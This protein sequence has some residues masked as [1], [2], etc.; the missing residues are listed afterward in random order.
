MA[1]QDERASGG[2]ETMQGNL[3]EKP[4]NA[5]SFDDNQYAGGAEPAPDEAD[6]SA[7]GANV[8]K[9]GGGT[10]S[11]KQAGNTGSTPN[12]SG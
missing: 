3:K 10:G 7:G 4:G 8:S 5:A 6:G 11:N 2:Q 9:Q 12:A 1:E